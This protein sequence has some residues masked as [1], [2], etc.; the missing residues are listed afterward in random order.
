LQRIVA[1]TH[2]TRGHR[3]TF[4]LTPI[5][6][7]A[8]DFRM[9]RTTRHQPR[10]TETVTTDSSTQGEI[11]AKI[12]KFHENKPRMKTH[13][14]FAGLVASLW[15]SGALAAPHNLILFVPDGLRAAIVD[16]TTAP[17]MARLREEGV[18]FTNSHS[19]FPTFTTANASAFA[20]GHGL[21]DTGD[22]SNTLYTRLPFQGSVTPFLENDIV[23]RE[24]NM[25]LGRNYLNEPSLIAAAAA[26]LD[27]TPISTALVGKLGPVAIF[28]PTALSGAGTLILDDNTGQKSKDVPIPPVW[29][30]EIDKAKL[31]QVDA[32][33]RGDNGTPGTFIAGFAQQQYFLEMT[34]KVVLP[35]FQALKSPFVLVYWTRDPDGTQHTQGDGGINGPTSMTAIRAADGALAAIEQTL[36]SLG[37]YDTTNIVV[38]ADH[39]FSTIAKDSE[40]GARELPTGFLAVDLAVALQKD[41]VRLQL[42]DPDDENKKVDPTTDHTSKGNGVIGTDPRFPQVVIAANGGSDLIYLPALGPKGPLAD[43]DKVPAVEQQRIRKLGLRITQQLLEKDYTSGLFVDDSRLGSVAGALSMKDIGLIGHAQ[44]P[45]P[46]IVVNFR[47]YLDTDCRKVEPLLCA[48][49]I[50]DTTYPTGGGMHGSF[51]RAD[52]WNFMAA[53]GPDFRDHYIDEL[54]ASNADIG[55]TMAQLLGVSVKPKGT[56]VGRVLTEALRGHERDPVASIEPHLDESVPSG[57]GLRTL[58]RRQVVAGHSYYDA[59]GFPGRTVGLGGR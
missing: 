54:P 2:R 45:R 31:K 11:H 39:G 44:T 3:G 29:R 35:R 38:V 47:S 13:T 57:N 34:L 21:G 33:P 49:E 53:R 9:Q 37:L 27:P 48:K 8:F 43:T 50:S 15:I 20:T 26:Q 25:H 23:L 30:T 41:D 59:A 1:C 16:P 58:L 5:A 42:F 55:M 32:P 36:K 46:A 52:T 4:T 17:T 56:L 40:H 10:S 12:A 24:L 22:Y 18:N 14:W 51:S 6:A 28:D 7:C 19:L